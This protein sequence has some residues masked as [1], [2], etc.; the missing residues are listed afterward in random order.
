VYPQGRHRAPRV[1]AMIEFLV[2]KFAAKP[3]REGMNRKAKAR[4]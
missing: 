3:W 1:A 4:A 2:E